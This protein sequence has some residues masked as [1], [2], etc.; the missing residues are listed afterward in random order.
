VS[1]R[2]LAAG[3]AALIACPVAVANGD[4]AARGYRATVTAVR[5]AVAGVTVEVLGSDDRL[6]LRN[7]SGRL[8]VIEGYDGE[9]YL[10]FGAS[11]TVLRNANSPAT[12]VNE[13]RYGG[14]DIPASASADAKPRWEQVAGDGT[15]EWH[16]HRIHWMSTI[17]PP[18]VRSARERPHHIFDWTVR[19][20]VA[21]AP[22]TIRGRL[23]YS[24]PPE[25][26]FNPIL[27]VPL[28][29]LALA[30]AGLWWWRLRRP[31]RG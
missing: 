19:G 17:D 21:S 30:A 15:Y 25:R 24:P 27:I 8:I 26:Q 3:L 31:A 16:D 29:A 22:F 1:V 4:G 12:Y 9:P 6:L 28:V 13:E 14:V 2:L 18:K 11:G 23:N 7:D 10:Q 20:E 5:P